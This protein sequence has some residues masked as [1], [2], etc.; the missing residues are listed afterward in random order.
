MRYFTAHH[1]L[2]DSIAYWSPAEAVKT[3]V[4]FVLTRGT[5]IIA[6]EAKSSRR[7]HDTD[8][9]GLRAIDGLRG[10]A[11]RIVVYTGDE[12][13]R[14]QDGIEAWPFAEFAAR[15]RAGTL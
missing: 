15:L 3:E 6:L 7:L 2:C 9:R 10:L 5:E 4:D 11:R 14:T 13:L 12:Q 8:F 1:D